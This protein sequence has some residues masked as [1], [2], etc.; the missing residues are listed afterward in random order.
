MHVAYYEFRH[1]WKNPILFL[2]V[3]LAPTVYGLYFGAIYCHAVLADIPLGIVD[4]DHSRLSRELTTAFNN[5]PYFKIISSISSYP[6]LEEA[7]HKGTVRAGIIIPENFEKKVQHNRQT[8]VLNV[9]DAS[10]LIWGLNTRKN[11]MEVINKFNSQFTAKYLTEAGMNEQETL[12]IV[13]AVEANIVTWYNPTNS[14][15]TYIIIGLMMMLLQQ[16]GLMSAGLTVTRE[17]ENN[18]WLH[19]IS[20]GISWSKIVLG[21]CLPYFLANFLNYILVV[22]IAFEIAGAKMEGSVWLLLIIGV[23]YDL[24]ITSMGFVISLLAEQSLQVTRYLT[25]LSLPIFMVSGYSW[26]ATHMPGFIDAMA[27]IFPS[28]WMM[29]AQ[30]MITVKGLSINYLDTTMLAMLLMAGVYLLFAFLYPYI[31]RRLPA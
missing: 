21:K 25:L 6:E 1:I 13:N 22:T 20:S 11:A 29:Q 17:K 9:Y 10:N 2:I 5:D 15:S 18:T 31:E 27:H 24:V 4:L 23:I 7:M 26:P 30:R 12:K 14:Y 19:F 16:L 3:F 8:G 28:T